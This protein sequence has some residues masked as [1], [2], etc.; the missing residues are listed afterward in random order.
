MAWCALSVYVVLVV[1]CWYVYIVLRIIL[2]LRPVVTTTRT[3]SVVA[4]VY[5]VALYFLLFCRRFTARCCYQQNGHCWVDKNAVR[6][7]RSKVETVFKTSRIQSTYCVFVHDKSNGPSCSV[8][9][10]LGCNSYYCCMLCAPTSVLYCGIFFI[11]GE[12][13]H[14]YSMQRFNGR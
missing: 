3:D 5:T 7:N 8:I 4:S 14:V 1:Q 10:V 9:L 12:W 6:W 2:W 13:R 11:T